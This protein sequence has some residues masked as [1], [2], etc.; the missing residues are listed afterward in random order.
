MAQLID[1]AL[2]AHGGAERLAQPRAY[3]VVVE[4]TAKSKRAPA[5]VSSTAT[6]SFQPPHQCPR[7]DALATS[8]VYVGGKMFL[9][10]DCHAELEREGEPVNI[11]PGA[12]EEL[13]HAK[14]AV[15]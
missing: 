10:A 2:K 11:R 5:G 7:C 4:M 1:R 3:T 9:C 8:W 12:L 15:M 6:H 14:C 13:M